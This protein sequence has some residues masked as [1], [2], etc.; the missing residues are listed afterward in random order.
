MDRLKFTQINMMRAI[1]LRNNKELSLNVT[2][3]CS[4][5]ER[6]K[7]LL[8][9]EKLEPGESLWIKPC[10]S[11]HTIGMKFPIDVA[12]LDKNNIVVKVKNNLPSNR[13]SGIYF[14]ASG[15][16]EFPAGTLQETNT[17]VGDRIEIV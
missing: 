4:L 16:L 8:G 10:N 12:F 7:G 13:I 17:Q 3:A 5:F 9:R 6:M 11:I 1:N 14:R 2:M 15:V